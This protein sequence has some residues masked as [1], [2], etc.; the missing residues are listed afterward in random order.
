M[1][2]LC[3]CHIIIYSKERVKGDIK[4]N[5]QIAVTLLTVTNENSNWFQ[6][7]TICYKHRD[8]FRVTYH[9]TEWYYVPV[10]VTDKWK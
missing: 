3:Y 5:S 1:S 8:E 2:C 4:K 9:M 10:T 7:L 6:S